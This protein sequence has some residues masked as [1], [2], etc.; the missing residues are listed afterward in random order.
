M[1]AD[2]ARGYHRLA[3]CV[4]APREAGALPAEPQLGDVPG[5]LDDVLTSDFGRKTLLLEGP[6]CKKLNNFSWVPWKT[7]LA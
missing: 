2:R 5:L 1:V 3:A 7:Q 6:L 4:L